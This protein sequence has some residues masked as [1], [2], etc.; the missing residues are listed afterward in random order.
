[1]IWTG[2]SGKAVRSSS[3]RNSMQCIILCLV[4]LHQC[5][6]SSCKSP[7]NR[8]KWNMRSRLTSCCCD[9]RSR[10]PRKFL[11]AFTCTVLLLAVS[12][13]FAAIAW[14]VF[15]DNFFIF[16]PNFTFDNKIRVS[17]N[18]FAALCPVL[19]YCDKSLATSQMQAGRTTGLTAAVVDLRLSGRGWWS[20]QRCLSLAVPLHHCV[21]LLMIAWTCV[22]P[23]GHPP[24]SV[25]AE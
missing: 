4:G 22:L 1:M 15:K 17:M 16:I 18:S 5:S 19:T 2:L 10:L 14:N 11:S 6:V 9:R 23:C 24:C 21:S 12:V 20:A 8:C 13:H 25:P 3:V 7:C